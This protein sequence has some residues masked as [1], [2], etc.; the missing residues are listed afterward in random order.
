VLTPDEVRAAA[1]RLDGAVEMPHHGFPS[2]RAG[3]IFATLP[4]PEHLHVMLH[5][6]DIRAAAAEWPWCSEKWWGGKLAAVR[7]TLADADPGV[8]DELLRDAHRHAGGGARRGG[9]QS[10]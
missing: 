9:G 8:V 6:G 1:L 2:F 10:S 5:E 3:R 4:D 7:V